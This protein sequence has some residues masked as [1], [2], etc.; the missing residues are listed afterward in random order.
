MRYFREPEAAGRAAP[1]PRTRYV[2]W[3]PLEEVSKPGVHRPAT[4]PR[5]R[6]F[7]P[8]SFARLGF[9]GGGRAFNDRVRRGRDR[10]STLDA[11][12]S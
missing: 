9:L 3:M 11:P 6:V 8:G 12:G 2:R 7:W 1:E 10:G 5:G 4:W